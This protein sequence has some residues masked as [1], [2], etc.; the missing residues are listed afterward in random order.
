MAQKVSLYIRKNGTRKYELADPKTI[1][2]LGTIFVLRYKR[3]GKRVWETLI[4]FQN[5]QTAKAHAMRKEIDRFTGENPA[6]PKPAPIPKLVSTPDGQLMLDA[7]VDRYL[8]NV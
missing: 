7:A 8:E 6:P 4:G 2:S 5:Y 1:Y 3:D